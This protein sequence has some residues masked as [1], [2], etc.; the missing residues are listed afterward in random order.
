MPSRPRSSKACVHVRGK[1]LKGQ[2]N[3]VSIITLLL[4]SIRELPTIEG[5]ISPIEGTRR[6]LVS[7][8]DPPEPVRNG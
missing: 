6:A 4:T 7:A 5:H 8:M 1:Y 2:G 3:L